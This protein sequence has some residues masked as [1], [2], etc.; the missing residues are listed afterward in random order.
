[1]TSGSLSRTYTIHVKR[2]GQRTMQVDGVAVE[3]NRIPLSDKQS[4]AVEVTL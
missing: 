2:T 4:V 1:M 3:G